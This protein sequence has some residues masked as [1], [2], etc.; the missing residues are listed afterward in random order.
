MS[1][2]PKYHRHGD[3][4][5]VV[6]ND[7]GQWLWASGPAFPGE[8]CPRPHNGAWFF[9]TDLRA[10]YAFDAGTWTVMGGDVGPEGPAGPEGPQGIQG[11]QGVPGDAGA[12]G[13]QGIQGIQGVEGPEGPQGP[14]G[15]SGTPASTVTSETSFGVSAAVGTST[16]YAR[17]DHTHGS[18]TDPV[19]AH[20]AAG[21]PHTQY[22]RESEKNAASGYA[23]LDG[24]SKLAGAQQVYGTG[25]N[26][27]CVGND[28]RLSDARTPTAHVSSHAN[29][30][31]DELSVAGLSGLLADGQTPLA[32]NIIT[33]HNGFPGGTSNFLRA[34]GSFAAP[35]GGGSAYLR[36]D[37]AV[38][39]LA[40]L[41]W[42]NMPAA[43]SFL[44]STAT[45]GKCI[46]KA[47]LTNFTQVRL[48]VNKQATAGAA[49]SKLILRYWTSFTQTVA[50]FADIGA[51]EVSVAVNV[52]NQFLATAWINLVAGAK[53]DVWL[54][55][56]GS[57]GDGAL[58]PA[59]GPITAEFK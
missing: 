11:I 8:G 28:A 6:G 21:D 44:F 32:H 30:G 36:V 54:A 3:I 58:D 35:P 12:Q 18:P 53:A 9:R 47:D 10:T 48:L 34:D 42:T 55:V 14:P 57:G 52:Q 39:V 50:T 56:L 29:G 59:F 33:A 19:T 25:A 26:T 13:Q 16:N 22:Q 41:A 24:S 37:F 20:V 4:I 49:S 31:G 38:P 43:L 51:S 7:H 5:I 46:T 40:A 15:D 23:G 2:R 45:V 1:E 27:A 17:E